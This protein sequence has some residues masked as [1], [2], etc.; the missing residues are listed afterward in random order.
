MFHLFKKVYIDFDDKINMSY[1]RVICS[2]EFGG[3]EDSVDLSRVFYG[4]RI[5]TAKNIDE[6][7][8]QDKP[9]ESFLHLLETLNKRVDEYKSRV[10]IYC[11]K[12]S[13]YKLAISWF[14]VILPHGDSNSAWKF[15][16]SHIFKEKNFAN[17]RL[18]ATS[19]FTESAE[20]WMLLEAE[21]KQYWDSISLVRDDK[22]AYTALL[23][24]VAP[25]MRIEFLLC[26]Y[27]YDGRYAEILAKAMTPLVRKD[28]EKFLYEHK[29]IILVHFQRPQFQEMLE[30]VNGPYDFDNFYDM[31]DDPAPLVQVMFKPDIWGSTKSTMSA[32][33]A[34]GTINLSAFT[35]EDIENLKKY[36]VI[37][38]KIWS[39][40]QWYTVLRSEIDKFDYIKMLRD[41]EFLSVE[42]LET[43]LS[44]EIH[45][46]NH[47]AGSFY[48]IDLRTVNTYFIDFILQH[49]DDKEK[50][51]PYVFEITY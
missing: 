42:D 10:F 41:K 2:E 34:S 21:F 5:A 45:N 25:S 38:G 12:E 8:G 46:I 44:Y 33:S 32:P 16:K 27:L 48:S 49:K 31:V 1:D 37:T 17:S 39:D 13:Y 7:I 18:S 26:S 40:E 14:K 47:A 19:R 35:D 9:F 15:F 4:E 51:K 22:T 36:S 3:I 11:D 29:E 6:L 43:I 30:V 24:D 50:I 20:S 23:E 28:L